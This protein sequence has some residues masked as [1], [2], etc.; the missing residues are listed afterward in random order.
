VTVEASIG[1]ALTAGDPRLAERL[2]ANLLDNAIRYNQPGGW[3]RIHTGTV[4]G[5]AT[6]RIANSGPV[7]P[8]DEVARLFG[9]FQRQSTDRTGGPNSGTGLGLSIVNAIAVAHYSWLWAKPRPEGGL[10]IDVRFSG[11]AARQG[12]QRTPSPQRGPCPV[13]QTRAL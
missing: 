5:L 11:A 1:T 12:P 3:V 7:I 6:L 2:I 8:P 13:S 10:E 4:D 9:P